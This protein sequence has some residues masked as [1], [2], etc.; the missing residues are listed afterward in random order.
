MENQESNI[1]GEAL[2]LDDLLELMG[3]DDSTIDEEDIQSSLLWWDTH[4]S[5]PRWVGSLDAPFYRDV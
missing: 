4:V 1:E 2:P 3:I 5:D